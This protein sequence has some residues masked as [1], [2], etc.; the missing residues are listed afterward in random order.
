MKL[1][2]PLAHKPYL[3]GFRS[4]WVAL[5]LFENPDF[6]ISFKFVTSNLVVSQEMVEPLGLKRACIIRHSLVVALIFPRGLSTGSR[7]FLFFLLYLLLTAPCAFYFTEFQSTY[8][9]YF[10]IDLEFFQLNFDTLIKGLVERFY[11]PV[12]KRWNICPWTI[13]D[14]FV[15]HITFSGNTFW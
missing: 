13:H 15:I 10:Q 5:I 2:N 9:L 1:P 6:K 3:V 14:Y 11:T 8:C 7:N 12:L 4:Y